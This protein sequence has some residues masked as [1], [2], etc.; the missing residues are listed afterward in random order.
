M[1]NLKHSGLITAVLYSK[2][3]KHVPCQT[4]QTFKH[5]S[6]LHILELEADALNSD[7]FLGTFWLFNLDTSY[8]L[9]SKHDL[10][11]EFER[12]PSNIM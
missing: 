2:L 3:Q 11:L 8:I 4:S 12:L 7:V 5:C 9:V 10:E 6:L 1:A